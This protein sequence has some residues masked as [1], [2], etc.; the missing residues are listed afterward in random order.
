MSLNVQGVIFSADHYHVQ[1]LPDGGIRVTT[2]NDD[3][4][5]FP[6]GD[7]TALIADF[8][9]PAL[10]LALGGRT[11]TRQTFTTFRGADYANFVE[12]DEADVRHGVWVEDT[13]LLEHDKIRSPHDWREWIR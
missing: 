13:K 11:N 10:D 4:D 12:P 2:W 3:P 1:S 8:L 7:F 5:D 6:D 9:P